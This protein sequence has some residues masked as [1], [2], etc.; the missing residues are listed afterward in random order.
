MTADAAVGRGAALAGAAPARPEAR[1]DPLEAR[2]VLLHRAVARI[3]PARIEVGPPR[4]AVV[5]PLLGVALTAGLLAALVVFIDSLPFWLLPVAL[6]IAVLVLPLSGISLVYAVF[7]AKVV[8]TLGGQNVSFKQQYL[9]LG[10][11]TQELVPFWKIREFVVEDV[12]RARV[13]PGGEEPALEI[14]QWE[15]ALIKKSGTRLSIAAYNVP[16]AD[17]EAGL[18][19]VWDVAEALSAMTQAPIRGPI[20]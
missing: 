6:L 3:T 15:L 7:G 2:E 18:D 19:V 16:R 9:G 11:G 12:A 20:W 4:S 14:A 17:E 1:A 10:V 8:A 13:H 5:V